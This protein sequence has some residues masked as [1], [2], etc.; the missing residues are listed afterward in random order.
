MK[1]NENNNNK[2]KETGYAKD[3]LSS[4]LFM[5]IVIIIMIIIAHFR[6]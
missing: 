3:V 4:V 6:P 1:D 2:E 5:A